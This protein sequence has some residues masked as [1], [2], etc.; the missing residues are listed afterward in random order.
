MVPGNELLHMEEIDKRPMEDL[1]L[2][3][4]DYHKY[5]VPMMGMFFLVM[6]F[7]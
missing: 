5:L 2:V 3:E 4:G 6:V 7:S 1:V